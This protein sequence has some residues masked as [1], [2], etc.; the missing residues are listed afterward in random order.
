MVFQIEAGV[1]ALETRSLHDIAA[2][3]KVRRLIE[4]DVALDI[5]RNVVCD[6]RRIVG[7]KQTDRYVLA[8]ELLCERQSGIA[9]HRMADDNDRR[10]IAAIVDDRLL[11]R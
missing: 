11:D 8:V 4:I 5:W 2:A 7:H 3:H 10:G 1:M 9:A 6:A